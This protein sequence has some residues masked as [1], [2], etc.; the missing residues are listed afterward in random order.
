MV[1]VDVDARVD[2]GVWEFVA[3]DTFQ[4]WTWIFAKISTRQRLA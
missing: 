3:R 4:Q 2:E 1:T